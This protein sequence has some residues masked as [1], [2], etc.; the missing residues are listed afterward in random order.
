MSTITKWK[1]VFLEHKKIVKT[2]IL[3][4]CL[5]FGLTVLNLLLSTLFQ[6]GIY[7]GTFIRF[8]YHIVVY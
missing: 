5:P 8:L 4:L 3:F 2:I 7:L 1:N 6:L